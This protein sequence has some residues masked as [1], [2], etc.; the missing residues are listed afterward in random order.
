MRHMV[1]HQTPRLPEL[2]PGTVRR[3]KQS[4]PW[5]PPQTQLLYRFID[6]RTQFRTVLPDKQPP[7]GYMLERV[8]GST[9]LVSLPDTKRVVHANHSFKVTD[10]QGELV[11]GEYHM[12]YV[13]QEQLVLM[14]SLELRRVPETGQETL[15]AGRGDPLF[16]SSEPLETLGWIE[17]CPILPRASEVLHTGPWAVVSLRRRA[18][19]R[20]WRHS[21]SVGTLDEG[22][23]EGDI[24]S[25]R[26]YPGP[27]MIAL[28][29]RPDGRLDSELCVPGRASRDPRKIAR[30]IAGPRR[31]PVGIKGAASRARY[32]T[33]HHRA[34]RLAGNDG[35][36]LGY[37]CRENI[38]GC[39][40]LF[41]TIHPVTGDQLVT[42]FPQE[43]TDEGYLMDG[44]LGAIFDPPSGD[45]AS[46]APSS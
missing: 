6:P 15:V 5:T 11:E 12:G 20:G 21:Y 22:P 27:E 25:L 37:L 17:A 33:L 23:G 7:P 14:D 13:E 34:R 19:A 43:A 9:H 4:E 16:H 26:R 2:T 32:L 18:D 35:E 38:P 3:W 8:L 41:S 28:R 36:T 30:W 42:R 1:V 40:T 31:S 10:R 39:S 29:L 44:I 24:G 46:G 45:A